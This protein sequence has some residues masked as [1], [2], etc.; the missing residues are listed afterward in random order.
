MS[1]AGSRQ[2][3]RLPVATS[4]AANNLTGFYRAHNKKPAPK[5]HR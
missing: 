2:L 1:R 5:S 3:T 4:P